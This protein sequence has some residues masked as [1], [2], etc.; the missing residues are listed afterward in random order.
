MGADHKGDQMSRDYLAEKLFV[1]VETL[2]ASDAPLRARLHDAWSGA[3][4]RL[5]EDD[6][7]SP[8]FRTRFAELKLA[9]GQVDGDQGAFS[10]TPESELEKHAEAICQL[11]WAVLPDA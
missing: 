8:E 5:E 6:F 7:P 11:L 2:G 9:A 10:A 4:V 3:L 1:G